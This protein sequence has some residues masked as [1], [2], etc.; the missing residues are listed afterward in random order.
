MKRIILI[1]ISLILIFSTVSIH[2]AAAQTTLGQKVSTQEVLPTTMDFYSVIKYSLIYNNNIRALRNLLSSTERD[3][4]IERS[5]MMPKIKF[6]ENYLA[7]NN[8]TENIILRANQAR[9]IANDLHV[10]TINTPHGVTNFLT[11]FVGEQKIIDKKAMTKISIAKKSYSA[12]T[13]LYARKQEE[14]VTQVAQTF[15]KV[16]MAKEAINVIEQGI[17]DAKEHLKLAEERFKN[18]NGLESDVLRA[19]TAVVEGEG[20]LVFAKRNLEVAQRSLGLLL[21]LYNPI[22]ISGDIPEIPLQNIDYYKNFSIYRT[23]IKSN[24]I[25]VENAKNY[26]KLAQA[27]YFPTLNALAWYNFYQPNYPFGGEGNSFFTELYFKWDLYDGGKRKCETLK[28]KDKQAEAIET[29]EGLRKTVDFK[30]FEAYT[31]VLE[32]QKKLELAMRA[33]KLEE[34][35][36]K[37]VEELWNKNQL[38]F[39]SL[40]EAQSDLDEARMSVVKNRFDLHEDLFNL[41]NESGII[42]EELGIK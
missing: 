28:A 42:F 17:S 19:K 22:E 5:E 18:K 31:N 37:E 7:S 34:K 11:S 23:D 2:Y 26:I 29:L 39:V 32:H 27:D 16:R 40:I 25:K 14:L 10:D 13:Y 12:N 15:L 41:C 24:E 20:K 1:I 33:Q 30:V 4:C 9:I 8:Q 6:R 36:A 3:I 38:P 21:G 35:D